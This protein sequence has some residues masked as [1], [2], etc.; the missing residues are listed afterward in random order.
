MVAP[1]SLD[2]AIH[3][4]YGAPPGE[5]VPR[6][7]ELARSLRADGEREAADE[8][9]ALRKPTVA[10]WAVNQLA[11]HEKMRLRALF[12]AG[13]RLRAADGP[14]ALERARDD[15]RTAIEALAGAARRL[16]EE[17]GHPPSESTV[18]SVRDTLHAA[19]VDEAAGERVRAGRLEKE[20]R[21]TGFAAAGLP[22]AAARKAAKRASGGDARR[23]KRREVEARL[24]EAREAAAAAEREVAARRRELEAADRELEIRRAAVARTERDL[25]RLG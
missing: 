4:L 23:R 1:T 18:D 15:E 20:E 16:L 21:A 8:V 22:P 9:K 7:D 14:E 13:E 2:T 24:S 17:A 12:A 19:V 6:R 5:F 3:G 11:R 10:A 25:E